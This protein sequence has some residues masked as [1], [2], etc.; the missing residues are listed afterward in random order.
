MSDESLDTYE[1]EVV[2]N[3][4]TQEFFLII[5]VGLSGDTRIRIPLPK[6]TVERYDSKTEEWR[7][8]GL[9]GKLN[10]ISNKTED[11]CPKCETGHLTERVNKVTKYTF[12]GCNKWPKCEYTAVGGKNPDTRQP[13]HVYDDFDDYDYYSD[14]D[15]MCD[16]FPENY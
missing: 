1:F 7:P 5:D 6:G 2:G 14:D 3:I 16:S 9:L 12:M 13:Q 15:W 10:Q 11:G 4:T 8:Q